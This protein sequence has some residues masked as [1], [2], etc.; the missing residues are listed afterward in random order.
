M[1]RLVQE[2]VQLDAGAKIGAARERALLAHV[3]AR[4]EFLWEGWVKR[5]YRWEIVPLV[6]SAWQLL[7]RSDNQGVYL[8]NQAFG[9]LRNLGNFAEAEPLLRRALALDEKRFGLNHP[10]VATCLNNLAA[11]LHD[12]NRLKEAEI[13]YRRALA[14]DAQSFGWNHPR[15]A[16]H[17]NNL[18][19]LLQAT[20]RL[21]EAEPFYRRALAIDQEVLGPNHPRVASHLNNLAQLL[22]A[23][24]RL[25]EA[26]PLYWHALDIDEQSFG[27]DN[28]RVATHL[29]N[30]ASLLKATDRLEE[31]EQLYRRALGIDE[32]SFG[33]DHPNVGT[34]LNNLA[35]LLEATNRL[36][37]AEQLMQRML[38]IFLRFSA[39]TGREHPFLQTATRNYA[40]LLAELGRDSGQILARLNNLTRRFD[41]SF[42]SDALSEIAMDAQEQRLPR[43]TAAITEYC[44]AL[45]LLLRKAVSFFGLRSSKGRPEEQQQNPKDR[46]R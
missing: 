15:V 45:T 46:P 8:A 43:S 6:A 30:L 39:S 41:I 10:N 42:G 11:L 37:E 29:N 32:R 33:W 21:E 18:A 19:Q 14:I 26:E 1:H 25:E 13:L 3:K 44:N 28:P 12:T 23:I 27:P 22:Q 17:L 36:E 4:S 31:A 9:P 7:E 24:N 34:D 2:A 5:E 16:T 38:G 20:D 40:A 35:A